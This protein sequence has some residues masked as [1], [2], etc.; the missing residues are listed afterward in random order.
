MGCGWESARGYLHGVGANI[1]AWLD[2]S[3]DRWIFEARRP[4]VGPSE[5]ELLTWLIERGG[6]AGKMGVVGHAL[7]EKEKY[8]AQFSVPGGRQFFFDGTLLGALEAAKAY[9]DKHDQEDQQRQKDAKAYGAWN[10]GPWIVD[11]RQAFIAGRASQRAED[12]K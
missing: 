7:N 9:A 11:T 8:C 3:D 6:V 5:C 1:G 12:G 10:S 4:I 2:K